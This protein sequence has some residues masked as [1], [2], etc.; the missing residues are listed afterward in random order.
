MKK[1]TVEYKALGENDSVLAEG[2]CNAR[3]GEWEMFDIC[4]HAGID[5]DDVWS[6]ETTTD[7]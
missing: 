5:M 6:M 7:V 4:T 1:R 3:E 2:E